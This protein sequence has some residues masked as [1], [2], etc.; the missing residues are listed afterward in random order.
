MQCTVGWDGEAEVTSSS[1][2]DRTSPAPLSERIHDRLFAVPQGLAAH[3]GY[4]EALAALA[5]GK[6][7]EFDG[8]NG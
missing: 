5:A 8:V 3:A 7:A 2:G 6:H 1:P 4:G